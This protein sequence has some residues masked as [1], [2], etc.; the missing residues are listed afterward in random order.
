MSEAKKQKSVNILRGKRLQTI[1]EFK[2]K[3]DKENIGKKNKKWSRQYVADNISIKAT[4]QTIKN[5]EKGKVNIDESLALIYSDFYNAPLDFILGDN[6]DMFNTNNFNPIEEDSII[7][8]SDRMMIELFESMGAN[9]TFEYAPYFN[10]ELKENNSKGALSNIKLLKTSMTHIRKLKG[11]SLSDYKCYLIDTDTKKPVSIIITHVIIDFNVKIK[12]PFHEFAFFVTQ[13]KDDIFDKL[14][15]LQNYESLRNY[16]SAM[17]C[18]YIEEINDV[19]N[20][21]TDIPRGDK[22]AIFEKI[23]DNLRKEHGE[24][25][26]RVITD[27]KQ[28]KEIDKQY[29]KDK[30]EYWKED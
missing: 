4:E 2:K 7:M 12:M 27:E 18:E 29:E 16:Y 1:R 5:H 15:G 10:A 11:F 8:D 26:I 14:R 28:I 20:G 6:D 22:E 9:I 21:L 24:D 30:K 13:L 25:V 17:E 23:A 3:T 19:K